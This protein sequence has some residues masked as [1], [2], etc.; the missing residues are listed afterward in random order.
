MERQL[1]EGTA[2]GERIPSVTALKGEQCSF[3]AEECEVG[4]AKWEVDKD[5]LCPI[6]IQTMRDAFLTACGHSFCYTCITTHLNNK[7][8]CPCCGLYLTNRQLFPNFLLNKLLKKASAYHLIG[9]TSPTEHFRLALQ[10]GLDIS[11]KELDCLLSLLIERKQKIEREEADAN[12]EILLDFLQRLRQQKQ[13]ELNEL[14]GDLLLIKE[15]I[16]AVE[17]QRQ[18]LKRSRE[19]Y[20]LKL[21]MLLDGPS[22]TFGD[23]TVENCSSEVAASVSHNE[24]GG[25]T[26]SAVQKELKCHT[27][28]SHEKSGGFIDGFSDVQDFLPLK[29]LMTTRKR[30]VLAQFNDLQEC[31]LQKRRHIASVP[32]AKQVDSHIKFDGDVN[33][34]GKEGCHAGLEE[35]QTVL[36]ACTRYSRVRVISE[37]RHGDLFQSSNIVS[38][39][40]FD[41][42]DEMFA[43]AGVSR[44][45]K[46]FEFATVVNELANVHFPVV[47]MATRSKLSCLSWN[48]YIK[49]CIAS[50]D[51]EG[52]VTVWDVNTS[53]SCRA[54]W[55]M[56][57]MRNVLGV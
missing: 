46:I 42:D 14:Q 44:R 24:H 25:A 52:I 23:A 18:E 48:K 5:F 36:S 37:F 49:S 47:E 26:L 20:S 16:A 11:V 3:S 4:S 40:E 55:S 30:R 19:G 34:E 12:M 1:T 10:Q 53:Q 27:F 28:A 17:R 33:V 7:D 50:S 39:I 56:R 8:N 43:T 9:N 35:F 45:I 6:C 22:V 38:S 54:L 32:Y 31:Y 29:G 21:R 51:Y 2:G 13:Q 41:R 15:D 57:N